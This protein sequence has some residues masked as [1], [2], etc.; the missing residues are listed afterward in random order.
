MPFSQVGFAAG[1]LQAAAAHGTASRLCNLPDYRTLLE[2][3]NLESSL[4]LGP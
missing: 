1:P 3:G 4:V 2:E